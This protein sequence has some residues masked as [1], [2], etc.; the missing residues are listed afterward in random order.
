MPPPDIA[1]PPQHPQ[2]R[3]LN[4][5]AHARPSAP[6]SAPLDISYVAIMG[7]AEARAGS[8][9]AVRDLAERAGIAPPPE[10]VDAFALD[11]GTF[12]LRWE[13]HTEFT[14]FAISVPADPDGDPFAR[15]A[16]LALPEGW[17]SALPGQLLVAIH[18]A[19]REGDGEGIGAVAATRVM[20]GAEPVGAML[21]EGRGTAFTDFRIGPDGF[22]RMVLLNHAMTATQA[23][24]TAQRL[25]EIESYRML[26]L[27]AFPIAR[28]LT[29]FLTQ[30]EMELAAIAD[31][32]APAR[33]DDE[34]ALLGRLTRLA[35]AV[36]AEEAAHLN[37]FSASSAYYDLVR[38]RIA[39]LREVRIEGLA[40]FAEFV[41]RRLAPAMAT[42]TAVAARH[43]ALSRRVARATQL[44]STRVELTRESQVLAVLASMDRR[45]NMQLRLQQTVEGLSTAA[46]TYYVVGLIGGLANGLGTARWGVSPGLVT[47]FSIPVVALLVW[48]G[49]RRVRRRVEETR[50][51]AEV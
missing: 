7:D 27:L 16:I 14:R 12:W 8:L 46:I 21:L 2:R 31:G 40:N 25:L 43:D 42:C 35:A 11:F 38:R 45:A 48:L 47:A 44:L 15:P 18:L 39:E 19:L 20:G 37:R 49:L 34:A 5:E 41:E 50:P 30:H 22:T 6:L 28:S 9:A 36:E 13:R 29:P 23:G 26:A 3:V 4:D 51:H 1:L 10:G 17:L 33:S 32:M 24:R